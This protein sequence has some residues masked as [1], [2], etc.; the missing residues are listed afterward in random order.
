MNAVPTIQRQR[1]QNYP[2]IRNEV[3]GGDKED[4]LFNDEKNSVTQ[5]KLQNNKDK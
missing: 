1:M 5:F 2:K 4:L 3:L